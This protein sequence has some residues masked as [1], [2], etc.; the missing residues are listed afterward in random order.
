MK[1]T[2]V[3]VI[4]GGIIGTACA[5][6]LVKQGLH[7]TLIDDQQPGATAAG[8]GLWSVWTMTLRS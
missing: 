4:G 5:W 1:S 7:V 8:M 2:D 3:A 6:Q